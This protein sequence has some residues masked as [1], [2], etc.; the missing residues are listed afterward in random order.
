M[1]FEVIRD[2]ER[3]RNHFYINGEDVTN[4][5]VNYEY[6]KDTGGVYRFV[7]QLE[8][9]NDFELN[10]SEMFESSV[11]SHGRKTKKRRFGKALRNGKRG[12]K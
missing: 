12:S 2:K 5:V 1:K 3:C 10:V 11:I 9:Y 7:A 6:K 8:F 4:H